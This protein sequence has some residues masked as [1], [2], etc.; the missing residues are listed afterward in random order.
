[1]A[2][3]FPRFAGEN[4]S[5]K[6]MNP[7]VLAQA[8][9]AE[10]SRR[11]LC[12]FAQRMIPWFET[13]T[14]I[15]YLASFLERVEAGG[16]K[17]L[18]ITAPPGHGKS[19]LL[20]AFT[21]WFI[22]RDARRRVLALSANESLARRNSRAVRSMLQSPEWPFPSVRLVGE[23]L[24]EWQTSLDGG[25][26][27]IGKSGILTGFRAEL[28]LLDDIQPDAGTPASR[29]D[30]EAFF[31]EIT[32]TRLE[33]NGVVVLIATRWA[34][35]DLVG[36]LQQGAS[37]NQWT[38]V[39][40]PAIAERNDPLS[41]AEGDA[42]WPERWPLSS[43]EE[44]RAEVGS[45]AFSCQYNGRPVP[46]EGRLIQ[47]KWF[48][49]YPAGSIPPLRRICMG[50]DAAAKTG[51]GNDNSAIVVVGESKNHDLYL[52]DCIAARVEFTDLLRM[53]KAAYDRWKMEEVPLHCYVEDASAGT[54][55]VQTLRSEASFPVTAVKVRD[56]KTSRLEALTPLFESGRVL[57]PSHASWLGAFLEELYAF[58]A[59]RHDDRV[60]AFA[61][62]L[63]E[64]NKKRCTWA[65]L[66][67]ASEYDDG[68]LRD[69]NG[70]A[71][72]PSL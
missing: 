18:A 65:F 59:A 9:S 10:L 32:A 25:V 53:L 17:R 62:V 11:S 14:H 61:L 46:P 58:P 35:D 70:Y 67:G 43:L 23:S 45:L 41:R 3:V 37:R 48:G 4:E 15:R 19:S 31:R 55:I 51:V 28:A 2:T 30:D 38:F 12:P 47:R 57:F 21:A 26:R 60:D 49:T 24:E 54:Q 22:G 29:E 13:P 50:L 52:L 20:N 72:R 39:S 36:R 63:S 69:G 44:R 7:R 16:I 5:E 42:L 1:M 34:E 71:Y 64:L 66:V 33:P 68:L 56:S 8:A 40:L 27:A 6:G